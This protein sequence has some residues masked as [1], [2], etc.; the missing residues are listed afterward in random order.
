[1]RNAR[2][3][4]ARRRQAGVGLIEVL[5]ALLVLSVGVLAIIGMQVSGKQANYDAV[6]RTT[7]AHL[8]AD[9]VERMRANPLALDSYL[10]GA[11]LEEDAPLAEPAPGCS[12]DTDTC[13][14]D[15]LAAD[16]LYEWERQM[17]G[18]EE[19]RLN[20]DGDVIP[21]GGL[22]KPRACLTGPAGGG[23]GLYT[24]TI[25]WRGAGTLEP[26]AL[27][28]CDGGLDGT[29]DYGSAD[30]PTSDAYRRVAAFTFF[31]TS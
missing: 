23:S 30:E 25:V 29:E 26:Q 20:A 3:S 13:S 10:T 15:E 18:L 7:A 9:L 12:S 4:A 31:I 21:T 6:Q 22:V 28:V 17:F 19:T 24:L 11:V 1:M 8:A 5:I 27:E 14:D 2:F 16:D